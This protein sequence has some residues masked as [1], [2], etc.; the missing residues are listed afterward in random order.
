MSNSKNFKPNPL[1]SKA[2]KSEDSYGL[3][4][5][6][7]I[8]SKAIGS[9]YQYF[10]KR[11][12]RIKEARAF[13]QGDQENTLYKQIY[14]ATGDTSPQN[15][16]WTPLGIGAKFVSSLVAD[17]AGEFNINVKAIDA[18][19]MSKRNEE[20][21][22]ILGNYFEREFIQELK[23]VSGIDIAEGEFIPEELDEVDLHMSITYKQ[24]VE[25][26]MRQILMY[27]L[28]LNNYPEEI[29]ESI[30]FDLIVAGIG[31]AKVEFDPNYGIVTRYV[32]AE[33]FVSSEASKPNAS[34]PTWAAEMR[35]MSIGD[36]RRLSGKDF[37]E[38]ELKKIAAAHSGRWDNQSFYD[39]YSNNYN[40][41][42][43]QN[44]NGYYFDTLVVPVLDFSF[45]TE[46]KDTIKVTK[47]KYGERRYLKSDTYKK[48][49]KS[50]NVEVETD[51]YECVYTGM[52][53]LG[54]EHIFNYG[55][56][57]NMVRPNKS[58]S[59]VE[60]PYKV[61]APKFYNMTNKSL[62]E[63]M[64]P[65]INAIN[66]AHL[67]MQQVMA[68]S[69]PEVTV[70]DIEG[71]LNIS[72]GGKDWSPLE[73]QDI[74]DATGIVYTK[75]RGE[76]GEFIPSPVQTFA[77]KV[78]IDPF[79][80][81]INYNMQL[82]RE[83]IGFTPE[84][85]GVTQSKQLVGV[86]ELSIASSRNSTRFIE[87]A[88]NEITKSVCRDIAWRVQDVPKTS[89]FWKT[90]EESIGAADMAVITSMDSIPLADFGIFINTLPSQEERLSLE[91]DLQRG[92]AQGSIRDEDAMMV[93]KLA[94]SSG[95]DTAYQYLSVKRKRYAKEKLQMDGAMKE[96]ETQ[97]ALQVQQ[98]AAQA[99][100]MEQQGEGQLIQM[101]STSEMEREIM[102]LR[103]KY[104][105]EAEASFAQFEYD[106]M[107]KGASD[108]GQMGKEKYKE[109]R[110]DDRVVKTAKV[111]AN[112]QQEII[113]MKEGKK[114]EVDTKNIEADSSNIEE[115]LS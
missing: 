83:T 113:K 75:S 97:R 96:Q 58:L 51:I 50:S 99:K 48:E 33:N 105:L 81:A 85:E 80:S 40:N 36:V 66:I 64:I 90:Y 88:L 25:I 115:L 82:I 63:L 1:A 106:M 30:L 16:D 57:R 20:K 45:K 71:W 93:K 47:S 62:M 111:N 18:A 68:K 41:S 108:E 24:S 3:A 103:E 14:N 112:Q 54:T 49:K 72:M 79:I 92:I 4:Y 13:A 17:I 22:K 65:Y 15:L 39:D 73:L 102:V 114:A 89:R 70:I 46:D 87:N 67:K 100:Q 74:F 26:A 77:N 59:K 10:Q 7:Y 86:T 12:D 98:A 31:I 94:R 23:E 110:K 76:N 38:A 8:Q 35:W 61:I 44:S 28:E 37:T 95:I 91:Q 27:N 11:R 43:N 69:H 56:M 109:D 55:L 19:S 52:Y 21:K 34:N 2:E 104:R 29:R 84:R 60:L 9:D 53:I 32:D 5:G 107:L 78:N 42:N 6:K 101:K